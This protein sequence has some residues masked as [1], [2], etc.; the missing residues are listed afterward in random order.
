ML[1]IVLWTLAMIV[2][3]GGAVTLAVWLWKKIDDADTEIMETLFI[4]AWIFTLIVAV[5][6][7]FALFVTIILGTNRLFNLYA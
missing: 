7:G 3:E 4:V 1:T 6:V 2:V 5:A